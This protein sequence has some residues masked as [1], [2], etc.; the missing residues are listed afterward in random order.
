MNIIQIT[1]A[2]SWGSSE[3]YMLDI[4]RGL[5]AEG[6]SVTAITKNVDAVKEPFK[7]CGIKVVTMPLLGAVDIVSPVRLAKLIRDIRDERI[8]IHVH[9]FVDAAIASRAR[10][11]APEANVKIVVT[12]HISS[13]A[14]NTSPA[15][16][17]Y[18]DIDAMIVNS[19]YVKARFISTAPKIESGKIHVITPAT[20][21][22]SEISAVQSVRDSEILTLLFAGAIT[23]EK[24]L[25]NLIESLS[26]GCKNRMRLIVAGQGEGP[27]VMPLI[28][29][30][31]HSGVAD[32]IEWRGD[33]P[34][35]EK[36]ID[37]ADA[38]ILPHTGT[39]LYDWMITATRTYGLPAIAS[40]IP[41][42]RE[43]LP[44]ESTIF[45]TPGSTT[46]LTEAISKMTAQGRRQSHPDA[47]MF[48]TF[49]TS[50]T[51][52]YSNI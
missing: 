6:H 3:R 11:L 22:F 40:D 25:S 39:E 41:V 14:K 37:T 9:N 20:Q 34:D 19:D 44:A 38:V 1:S 21:R 12:R 35:V 13:P 15:T 52:L 7:S 49:I 48:P 27:T 31:R 2:K 4:C 10:T 45:F 50:I 24:G 5:R 47:T 29:A 43:L 28:R 46:S 16:A 18:D 30:A 26:A 23:P 42:H 8:I 51:S 17:I 33:V 32:I 36:L